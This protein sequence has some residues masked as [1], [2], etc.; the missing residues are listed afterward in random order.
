MPDVG[1]IVAA[2]IRAFF[3]EPHNRDV[4]KRLQKSGVTWPEHAPRKAAQ[5]GPLTGKTFVLTGTLAN[6]TRD[7]AKQ[8]II[9][10][11]GKVTGSVSKKTD[12]VVYGEKPGSKLA[13]AQEFDVSTL[14]ESEFER[15]LETGK[16][17]RSP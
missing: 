15:L 1:P 7:E 8:R 11:G 9:E 17:D 4:I 6:M 14:D 3:D 16:T 5:D 13:K 10:H 2:R 12:F